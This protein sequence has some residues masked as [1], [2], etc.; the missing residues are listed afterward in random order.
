MMAWRNQVALVTGDGCGI[1][2]V[3]N[4]EGA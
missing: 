3:T 2:C 4:L 1:G